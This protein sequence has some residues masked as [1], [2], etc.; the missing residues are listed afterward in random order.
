[1]LGTYRVWELELENTNKNRIGYRYG[2][3]N[4][5]IHIL[6]PQYLPKFVPACNGF[7]AHEQ[8]YSQFVST[9]YMYRQ[10]LK[11][12]YCLVVLLSLNMEGI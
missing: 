11:E 12:E 7:F 3:Q 5:K 4:V 8:L 9:H 2:D 6:S 1:M 10:L